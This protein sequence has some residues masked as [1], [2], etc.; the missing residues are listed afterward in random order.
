MK[1]NGDGNCFR[2]AYLW[3]YKGCSSAN[4]DEFYLTWIQ[5]SFGTF[6]VGMCVISGDYNNALRGPTSASSNVIGLQTTWGRAKCLEIRVG[7]P[8]VLVNF[9]SL[10][11]YVT[12][13]HIFKWVQLQPNVKRLSLRQ[14]FYLGPAQLQE[15]VTAGH[16]LPGPSTTSRSCHCA[17]CFT[18]FQPSLKRL[19]LRVMVYLGPAQLQEIVTAPDVLPVSSPAWRDCHCAW[20]FTWVQPSFKK[21]CWLE[22]TEAWHSQPSSPLQH[23]L[24]VIPSPG[25]WLQ[26]WPADREEGSIRTQDCRYWG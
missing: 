9:I 7:V 11:S 10:M 8:D 16:V 25:Q 21:F 24:V 6:Q 1:G 17:I 14:M 19:S 3:N 22:R 26:Q 15:V 4:F 13:P 23:N 18:W 5:Q 20:Y 12:V 2:V